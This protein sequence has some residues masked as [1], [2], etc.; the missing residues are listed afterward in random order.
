MLMD[1][2]A[3]EGWRPAEADGLGLVRAVRY[4][5][6]LCRA[7]ELIVSEY[8]VMMCCEVPQR[9]LRPMRTGPAES[10][11]SEFAS[12]VIVASSKDVWMF[13]EI[14]EYCSI[15]EL[16]VICFSW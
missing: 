5:C 1:R 4:R 14:C 10:M 6:L 15:V 11:S 8:A 2:D 13:C 7:T 9:P 3:T 12:N 16:L